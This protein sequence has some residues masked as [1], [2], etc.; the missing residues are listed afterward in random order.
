MKNHKKTVLV[1][2]DDN[3]V[4]EVL[5]IML[6]S[7]N[8]NVSTIADG[9]VLN[10]V[11]REKPDVLLLDVSMRQVDG[12]DICRRLKKSQSTRDIPVIMISASYNVDL[13][14]RAAGADDFIAKPFDM[15]DLLDKVDKQAKKTL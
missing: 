6:E 15:Y 3:A 12:R 14:S 11:R 13:S 10:E 7:S 4:L 5:Q 1:A 9:K 2:D 8:Y